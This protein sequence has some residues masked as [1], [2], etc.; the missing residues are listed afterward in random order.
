M[1]MEIALLPIVESAFDPFAYSHAR[2]SG[3]WQFIPSTAR[4]MHLERNWWYDGRRDILAAT[5]AAL[6]LLQRLHD[7]LDND[8]LLALAA[9]NSG[10]GNVRK[11]IRRNQR[12]HKPTDFWHLKLPRETTAYVPKLL[13]L[14]R[15]Y[16]DPAKYHTYILPIPDEPY[17]A[18]ADTHSQIDLAQAAKLAQV[19]IEE[20]Y[21][22]NPGLNRWATDPNGPHR[23]LLPRDNADLFRNALKQLPEKERIHWQQYTI[24]SGDTLSTVAAAFNV[25]TDTLASVN[26][27]K[28]SRITAGRSLMIPVA[29]GSNY[30]LSQDQRS[31]KVQKMLADLDSPKFTH[32]V[33][34]GESLWSISRKYKT[35]PRKLASW[36]GMAERDPLRI[37]RKL[38]IWKNG[39][40]VLASATPSSEAALKINI[41]QTP[42]ASRDRKIYYRVRSGDSLSKIAER[43][44]TSVRQISRWNKL[45]IRKI[46]RPGQS[47]VIY[48]ELANA[49]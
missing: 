47:L 38:I 29:S 25:S 40:P 41:P 9:Y 15:L 45:D 5:D 1:P 8:W 6:N 17:F 26:R 48:T 34:K 27:I 22:L 49:Y 19:D 37:G 4:F 46:I 33:R 12:K 31:E 44:N 16:R 30:A 7:R 32:T 3:I 35:T 14:A 2:A 36:N 21:L 43:F 39:E 23:L 13:A 20:V 28:N 18:Q 42:P 11:A 10:E 24:K